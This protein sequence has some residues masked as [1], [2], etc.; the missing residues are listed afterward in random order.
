LNDLQNFDDLDES[1]IKSLTVN[2][3]VRFCDDLTDG[4]RLELFQCYQF[5]LPASVT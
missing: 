5:F 4:V 1:D 3:S 2:K